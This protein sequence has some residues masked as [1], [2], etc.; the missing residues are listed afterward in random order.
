M[1]PLGRAWTTRD[2][3]VEEQFTAWQQIVDETY[4]P[5][6]I[7]HGPA[8]TE[9]FTSTLTAHSVGDVVVS[10]LRSDSQAVHRTRDL[11]EAA[12]GEVYFLNLP[13]HGSGIA[14]QDGRLATTTPGDF[15]LIDGSRPF[16]L[17]FA[18]PFDQIALVIPHH[19]IDPLLARPRESTCLTVSGRSAAGMVASAAVRA[20]AH[21]PT[22]A[23]ART[24]R[25][26]TDHVIGLVAL[27]V[28][29]TLP[30][31]ADPR[32]AHLQA[33]LDEIDRS[34]ADPA[35]HPAMV[36]R[37]VCI[38]L[39]YLTK[40]FAAHGTSFGR[41]VLQRRLDR[42]YDLLGP[43]CSR[44]AARGTVTQVAVACGFTD[45]AHFARTFRGRFGITPS[46]RLAGDAT[47]PGRS[48]HDPAPRQEGV[49]AVRA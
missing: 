27:A 45:P 21:G 15:V 3:A 47:E 26:L 35:L 33:A 12:P 2:V 16:S 7:E 49:T 10:R 36:A 39:S 23:D 19:L 41:V 44:P 29:G 38:S 20:L 31:P 11:V 42:A 24:V 48:P 5:V 13:T 22:P 34:L 30:A 14:V 9:G 37:Q 25:G 46:Q 32:A 43:D 4:L 6:R 40:L 17:A 1:S 8:R 28:S 18:D